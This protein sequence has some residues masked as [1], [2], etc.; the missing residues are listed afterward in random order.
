MLE[1]DFTLADLG[2]ANFQGS[3]LRGAVFS[4]T[5]LE[6]TD[7]RNAQGFRLDPE[8]NRIKGAR[9]DLNGLPG[10]LGKY[11]IKAG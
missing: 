10:L 8:L 7:F 9:F 2:S 6:K 3:D 4:R 11:G 5:V 1:A